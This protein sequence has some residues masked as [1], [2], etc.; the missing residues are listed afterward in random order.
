MGAV[1]ANKIGRAEICRSPC[2]FQ[3]CRD[4]IWVLGKAY[5]SNPSFYVCSEFLEP[6]RENSFCSVLR[7]ADKPK[8]NVTQLR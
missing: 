5:K 3:C 6:T 1:G 7:N 2:F 4:A 8:G